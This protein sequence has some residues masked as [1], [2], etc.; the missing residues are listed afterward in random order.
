MWYLLLLDLVLF[1]TI[2]SFQCEKPMFCKYSQFEAIDLVWSEC[3]P[4]I[5]PAWMISKLLWKTAR[6]PLTK[7][8]HNKWLNPFNIEINIKSHTL[9]GG[10]LSR[11][12]MQNPGR[13]YEKPRFLWHVFLWKHH[14]K[15]K[16]NLWGSDSTPPVRAP[17]K[18]REP[19]VHLSLSSCHS[20]AF[21]CRDDS[22]HKPGQ[23][24]HSW[25][26]AEQWGQNYGETHVMKALFS[27]SPFA[28]F[29]LFVDTFDFPEAPVQNLMKNVRLGQFF[30]FYLF[31]NIQQTQLI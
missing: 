21:T 29:S 15:T 25:C 1:S 26:S 3:A 12:G 19:S 6:I 16:S 11:P 4:I 17:Q 30:Y 2:F 18:Q 10:V 9:Q 14:W 7:A 23:P 27:P 31:K 22:S 28:C 13:K 5:C 8:L 24:H 20:T